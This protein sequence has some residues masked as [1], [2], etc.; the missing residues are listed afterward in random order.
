MLGYSK[1][2]LFVV[3]QPPICRCATCASRRLPCKYFVAV[4]HHLHQ[5]PKQACYLHPQWKLHTHPMFRDALRNLSLLPEDHGLLSLVAPTTADRAG[6]VLANIAQEVPVEEAVVEYGRTFSVPRE[7]Y[8]KIQFPKDTFRRHNDLNTLANEIV[9]LGKRNEH[10]FKIAMAAFAA[11]KAKLMTGN[12]SQ[13]AAPAVDGP[14]VMV[15]PPAN[16]SER[17]NENSEKEAMNVTT[18]VFWQLPSVSGL[19]LSITEVS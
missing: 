1:E 13:G 8:D 16:K 5:N 4:C 11:T 10:H 14:L 3:G 12:A 18:P 19:L 15:L 7:Q 2:I 6:Q 9:T 17:R